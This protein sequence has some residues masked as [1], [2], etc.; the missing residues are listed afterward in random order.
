MS[1]QVHKIN[2]TT[3]K[4]PTSF[5]IER[6]NVTTLERL[7]NADMAGDLL[8]KKR[9]FYYTYEAITNTDLNTILD[10]IWETDSL[11]FTLEVQEGPNLNTYQIYSGSIPASLYRT[12]GEWVWKDVTFNLIEK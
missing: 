11:F 12:G 8:A 7:A 9:K 3:I 2:G 4:T 10:I 5:K 6:F 1:K